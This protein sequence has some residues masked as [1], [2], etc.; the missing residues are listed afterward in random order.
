MNK[1]SKITTLILITCLAVMGLIAPA[2]SAVPLLPMTVY[3]YVTIHRI[4]G[5]NITAPEGLYVYA[6]ENTAI[7]NAM[8]T[9]T[10]DANG[11]YSIGCSATTEGKLIDFWV[12]NVNVTRVVFHSGTFLELN[13]TVIDTTAPEIQP[14]SPK[15]GETISLSQPVWINATL[16]DNLAV[17]AS[18]I[19]MTLNETQLSAIYDSATG[20]LYNKTNLTDEGLYIA[21][22]Y[23][24][25]IAGNNATKTWNF[26]AISAAPP[27]IT[28]LNPTTASPVYTQSGK[29]IEIT[30]NYTE[31]YPFNGTMK[32]YNTTSTVLETSNT[33]AITPGTNVTQTIELEIPAT[34]PEGKYDLSVTMNNIYSL[35]A[36]AT[37]TNAVVIDNSPPTIGNP[38][39]EPPGQT[40]QPSQTIEIQSG[41]NVTVRV[42]VTD[43]VSL[44]K[45]V[46]LSYNITAT[47]W[48]NIEMQKTTDDEYSATIPS[49]QLA[50]GTTIRYYI[51]AY[52]SADN[53]AKSPTSEIYFQYRVIPEFS[54]PTL[55]TALMLFT[56]TV[57]ILR[58]RKRSNP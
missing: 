43:E 40:A 9:W 12:Q 35:S 34:A 15:P 47:Q 11:Y 51:T 39:Q 45:Q 3:G 26:T 29:T 49:S 53:M 50:V 1:A 28:I 31:L 46:I 54:A 13:L 23:A 36:T 42:T 58:R 37:Q 18:T 30:F 55:L 27:V 22:V 6:K 5:R 56:A 41:S 20:L 32:V 8:G 2:K 24:E 25:D 16:T 38:Y 7:I 52:D 21:S 14:L 33:T 19:K 44:V 57:L 4:D 48:K 17:N 10:T